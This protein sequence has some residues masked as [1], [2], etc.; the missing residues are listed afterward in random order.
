V[1]GVSR[2]IN[3]LGPR[4]TALIAVGCGLGLLFLFLLVTAPDVIGGILGTILI[5][6]VILVVIAAWSAPIWIAFSRGHSSALGIT[7]LCLIFG[8]T[9]IG[10]I[11]ALVWSLSNPATPLS[12]QSSSTKPSTIQLHT[13]L[14]LPTYAPLNKPRH[15]LNS[16]HIPRRKH[17]YPNTKSATS[18]TDT[19]TTA[20]NGPTF[21]NRHPLPT[22]RDPHAQPHISPPSCRPAHS[23]LRL[24]A[25]D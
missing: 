19:V 25:G 21:T 18:S 8:W 5:G 20:W 3:K 4:N 17:N 11:I 23:R 9:F 15:P 7:L 24:R 6:V 22:K 14:T 16:P 13:Q 10:W 1:N 12:K 2:I